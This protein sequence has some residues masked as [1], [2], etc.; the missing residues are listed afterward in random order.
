MLGIHSCLCWINQIVPFVNAI[1]FSLEKYSLQ[2]ALVHML[3]NNVVGPNSRLAVG[4]PLPC[5]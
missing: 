2:F 4:I 3:A 5:V 1:L